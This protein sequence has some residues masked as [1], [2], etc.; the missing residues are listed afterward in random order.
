[1]SVMSERFPVV[2]TVPDDAFVFAPVALLKRR[3]VVVDVP[4]GVM[5]GQTIRYGDLGDDAI[6][7]LPRG[8][9]NVNIIVEPDIV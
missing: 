8:N 6:P 5:S 3:A 7:Q 2:I 9:L 1:M 4:A